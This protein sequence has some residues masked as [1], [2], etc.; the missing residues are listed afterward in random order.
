MKSE[1]GGGGSGVDG[2]DAVLCH[3]I[4]TG[5]C[6]ILEDILGGGR[7][8]YISFFFFLYVLQRERGFELVISAST[9]GILNG[10]K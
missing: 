9:E 7:R 3:E 5:S 8:E 1:R 6:V 10:F 2:H 4:V